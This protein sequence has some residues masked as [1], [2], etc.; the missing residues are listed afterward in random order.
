MLVP[1]PLYLQVLSISYGLGNEF[2]N[3]V[4]VSV[5]FV[6]SD[7]SNLTPDLANQICDGFMSLGAMGISVLVAS[8]KHQ[9]RYF[10]LY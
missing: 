5:D 9:H 6:S 3:T 7:E 4:G 8:G 1:T 10:D 2:T